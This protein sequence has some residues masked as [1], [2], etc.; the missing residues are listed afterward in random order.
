MNRPMK[1]PEENRK[2]VPLDQ[3]INAS[4]S[5]FGFRFRLIWNC[6]AKITYYWGR[7]LQ[8]YDSMAV[9]NTSS[10]FN[11]PGTAL[12]VS[13]QPKLKIFFIRSFFFS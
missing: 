13:R 4:K 10:A 2:N 6:N 7:P 11:P 8:K 9:L 12:V 5:Y 3:K 1:V